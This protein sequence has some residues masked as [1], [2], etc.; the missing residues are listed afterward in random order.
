MVTTWDTQ[1]TC[2]QPHQ[3]AANYNSYSSIFHLLLFHIYRQV[4]AEL[5]YFTAPA[6]VEWWVELWT[7]SL[8]AICCVWQLV[9][10]MVGEII[11]MGL[12]QDRIKYRFISESL[13]KFVSMVRYCNID[14][15]IVFCFSII[16]R[17]TSPQIDGNTLFSSKHCDYRLC[18]FFVYYA[19][20]LFNT[21]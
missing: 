14:Y 10:C 8:L 20:F 21:V 7:S 2:I 16:M 15:E 1:F 4:V 9:K 5:S 19:T 13:L 11:V 12:D 18:S 6:Y 3:T 17:K